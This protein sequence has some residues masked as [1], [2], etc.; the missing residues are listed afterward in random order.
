MNNSKNG[1]NPRAAVNLLNNAIVNEGWTGDDFEECL[2]PV[3]DHQGEMNNPEIKIAVLEEKLKS[4]EKRL[5]F[6]E[7][8]CF[9][10]ISGLVAFALLFIIYQW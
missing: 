7:F 9:A 2:Q 10:T 8:F 1:F 3:Y 4:L 6:V 5:S